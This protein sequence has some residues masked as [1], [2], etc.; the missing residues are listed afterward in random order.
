MRSPARKLSRGIISSRRT[1]PSA[2]P[3]STTTEPNSERLTMPCTISPIRSLYSSYWRS[4]SA[5]RTFCTITALAA[6]C[7]A[8]SIAVMTTCLSIDL[9]R[10]TASAICRSS[11]RLAAM[12][13][14][15]FLSLRTGALARLQI[16]GDERVAQHQLGFRD[17][18]ERDRDALTLAFDRDVLSVDAQQQA[19]EPL[20]PID[21]RMKFQ[22]GLVAGPACEVGQPGQRPVDAGRGHFQLEIAA[23]RVLALDEVEQSAAQL[24]A[25]L[26]IHGAIGAFRHDLQ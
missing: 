11:V 9:S 18:A 24:R 26:D 4:R 20:A 7:I 22:L 16:F 6:R 21:G 12:E 23:H 17:A 2:R 3:R 25:I 1:T 15:T 5:S 14:M 13:A 8:S 19:A 10:A